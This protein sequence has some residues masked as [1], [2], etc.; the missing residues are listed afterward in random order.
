[1]CWVSSRVGGHAAV[2]YLFCCEGRLKKR[3]ERCPCRVAACVTPADE[4]RDAAGWSEA[5]ASMQATRRA[6]TLSSTTASTRNPSPLPAQLQPQQAARSSSSSSAAIK[7]VGT[8]S[9][10]SELKNRSADFE[11]KVRL[12][13][14]HISKLAAETRVAPP[15][16][17]SP[18][19]CRLAVSRDPDIDTKSAAGTSTRSTQ[20][21][22]ARAPRSS[23]LSD[24]AASLASKAVGS[25]ATPNRSSGG[26]AVPPRPAAAGAGVTGGKAA[27]SS[28]KSPVNSRVGTRAARQSPARGG[29]GVWER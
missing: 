26:D 18:K 6:R 15:A 24:R 29:A 2:V 9:R 21:E 25:P 3:K 13:R 27:A 23:F 5:A 22:P 17:A 20:K 11:A 8:F 7:G 19:S 14:E 12:C 4:S 10:Q 28:P 1:M 16:S